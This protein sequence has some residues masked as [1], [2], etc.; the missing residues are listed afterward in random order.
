MAGHIGVGVGV[1]DSVMLDDVEELSVDSLDV[2]DVVSEDDIEEV[3][4]DSLDVE[5]IVEESVVSN[6]SVDDVVDVAVIYVEVRTPITNRV[7]MIDK[8]IRDSIQIQK[9]EKSQS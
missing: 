2:E 6:D 8:R 9:K 3:S 1:S 7:R 5:V 4:V